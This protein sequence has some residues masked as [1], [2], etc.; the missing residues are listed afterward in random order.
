MTTV[1][2]GR[3]IELR[4]SATVALAQPVAEIVAQWT[5]YQQLTA[6]LLDETDYQKIGAKKFKKKSAWRKYAR[7]FNI[8]DRVVF[9]EIV[10]ADDGFPIYARVR[11]E[12]S[13]PAT[14]R[15]A[16][17]DHE[18]HVT[19]KCCNQPCAKAS[20]TN[21]TCCSPSC[22]GRVH[23]SHPGDI[24]ATATT[25]AKNRAISDL[26]GAGEVS[27]EEMTNTARPPEDGT[28]EGEFTVL[29]SPA[30]APPRQAQA[31]SGTVACKFCNGPC[32][33]NTAPG[34]K[35]VESGPDYKCKS[36][37]CGAAA[38]FRDGDLSWRK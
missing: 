8:S 10:R 9:E 3:E 2:A 33:D 12:A 16:Q 19:E 1:E 29:D 31:T 13:H 32:Y 7:A 20:W 18:C 28:V 38:W 14:G 15:S 36:A 4:P 35:R 26:I 11:V 34:A 30:T 21:H 27:A 22:N 5:E 37:N 6:A 25:R 24:P 17:A 23:F